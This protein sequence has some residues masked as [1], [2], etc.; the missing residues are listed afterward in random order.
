MW[1]T[2]AR[3]CVVPRREPKEREGREQRQC[4]VKRVV[5]LH[6]F[7]FLMFFWS[8]SETGI[9][10]HMCLLSTAGGGYK[11]RDNLGDFLAGFPFLDENHQKTDYLPVLK[12]ILP[13][14]PVMRGVFDLLRRQ[15]EPPRFE[16]M[17]VKHVQCFPSEIPLCGG[18]H[19]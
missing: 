8:F 2:I 4:D 15:S 1:Y 17:D 9:G 18:K 14:F 16:I 12:T 3:R 5:A 7:S 13:D 11:P 19:R 6:N 10:A